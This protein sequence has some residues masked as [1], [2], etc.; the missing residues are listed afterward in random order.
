MFGRHYD[1]RVE[2]HFVPIY[3]KV[4][5]LDTQI[6]NIEVEGLR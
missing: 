2:K 1:T 6:Y 4:P 5:Y 3:S